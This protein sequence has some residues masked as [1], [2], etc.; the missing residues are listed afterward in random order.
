MIADGQT[1]LLNGQPQ[2]A[3]AAGLAIVVTVVA[4][5]LLG[6]R[7]ADRAEVNA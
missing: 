5:N 4:F 7:L 6:E 2:A 1:A 3:L